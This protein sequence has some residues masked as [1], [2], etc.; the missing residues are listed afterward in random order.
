MRNIGQLPTRE[1]RN[2]HEKLIDPKIKAAVLA[3][4]AGVMASVWSIERAEAQEN[5]AMMH[6][7]SEYMTD[8][9]L[10][11]KLGISE[12]NIASKI[13]DSEVKKDIFE[14]F[15]TEKDLTIF[16]CEFDSKTRYFGLRQNDISKFPKNMSYQHAIKEATK[17]PETHMMTPDQFRNSKSLLSGNDC[18]YWLKTPEEILST[19]KAYIAIDGEI[20]LVPS[21]GSTI[22]QQKSFITIVK[23][24]RP[25]S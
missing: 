18:A 17:N 25:Q 21:D 14:K 3:I 19:G 12:D 7:T 13:F 8:A 16:L 6:A 1:I 9:D 10:Y 11:K 15:G 2:D 4:M 24:G 5:N 20:Q 23:T 22:K